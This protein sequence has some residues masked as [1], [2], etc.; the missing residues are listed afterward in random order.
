MLAEMTAREFAEWHAFFGAEP[1]VGD[2]V[3]IMIGGLCALTANIH[4]DRKRSEPF[5]PS[6]F[7][8][9]RRTE[10]ERARDEARKAESQ[11]WF[12]QQYHAALARREAAR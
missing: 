1:D 5:K 6:D 12:V 7:M 9:E 11:A 10:V 2:R 8:I 4:R 3:E